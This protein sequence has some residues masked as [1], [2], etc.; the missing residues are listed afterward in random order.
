MSASAEI[1]DALA[2]GEG[3]R[4]AFFR[5]RVPVEELAETFAAFANHNGGLTLLGVNGRVRAKLVG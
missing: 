2:S 5:E 4:L 1:K 3:E